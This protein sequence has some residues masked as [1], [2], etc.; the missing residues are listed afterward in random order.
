MEFQ[1]KH[2]DHYIVRAGLIK[3]QQENR[4][5]VVFFSQKLMGFALS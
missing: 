2:V 4:A 3:D 5:R 1:R